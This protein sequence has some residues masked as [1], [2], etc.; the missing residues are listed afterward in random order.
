MSQSH[1]HGFDE[2]DL[3]LV[4]HDLRGSLSVARGHARLLLEGLRGPLT[5]EQRRS[6]EAIE[7]QTERLDRLLGQ[8]E[9]GEVLA[10]KPTE[11]HPVAE[12][13][14]ERPRILVADDD[15]D[16]L[17]LLAELLG[18]RYEVTLADCGK[19]A[20]ERLRAEPFELA[21]VD[22]GLPDVDGFALAE[23][24]AT[25]AEVPPAF[26]FLSAQTSTNAKVKGLRLGAADYVTKPFDSDELLARIAR[27]IAA[28]ERERSLRA[29]ALTDPL[30]GLANYRSLA[31]T[32]H[33]E[34]ERAKRYDL[35]L[36]LM[37]IDVDD[38]KRINDEGGHSAGDEAILTIARI[39]Q[40]GVRKF[41]TVARQGGDE[42][43]IVLP[44]TSADEAM[45]LADRLR[46]EVSRTTVRGRPLSISVG[47]ASREKGDE[48][49]DVRAL[50]ERSDEALYRAKRAGRNRVAGP[51]R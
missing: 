31:H 33:R 13:F 1:S 40:S 18:E 30:T 4:A 43:A 36:S 15:R 27:I 38:L 32:L 2:G 16:L 37:A 51:D 5:E 11:A 42:L 44:N 10:P 25:T 45:R 41:E 24:I 29:D 23:K 17:E 20:L 21:I 47:V 49:T 39:L 12:V 50:A 14:P 26:M 48:T 7:R 6:I 19:Q 35:P 3:A 28:V 34:L 9:Q 46:H 8:L 22:L